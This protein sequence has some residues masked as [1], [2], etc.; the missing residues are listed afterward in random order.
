MKKFTILLFLFLLAGCSGNNKSS[1]ENNLCKGFEET[2]PLN[3][4]FRVKGIWTGDNFT[5]KEFQICNTSIRSKKGIQITYYNPVKEKRYVNSPT[6][7][8]DRLLSNGFGEIYLCPLKKD[9]DSKEK[10]YSA[11]I[12]PIWVPPNSPDKRELGIKLV[13]IS[14]FRMNC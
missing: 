3:S 1:N 9:E 13:K 11:S 10:I 5:S 7:N 4:K 6:F 2:S 14:E 12:T 8:K